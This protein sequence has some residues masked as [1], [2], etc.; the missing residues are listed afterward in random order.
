MVAL[1]SLFMWVLEKHFSYFFKRYTDYLCVGN[2]LM[3][4]ITDIR[5]TGDMYMYVSKLSQ[6]TRPFAA[7]T[8]ETLWGKYES[9]VVRLINNISSKN[10]K[11]APTSIEKLDVLS[12]RTKSGLERFLDVKLTDKRKNK[13]R[14]LTCFFELGLNDGLQQLS[15][16]WSKVASSM[17]AELE[18]AKVMPEQMYLT[19]CTATETLFMVTEPEKHNFVMNKRGLECSPNQYLFQANGDEPHE[20][21]DLTMLESGQCDALVSAYHLVD[22]AVESGDISCGGGLGL[23]NE[24]QDLDYLQSQFGLEPA[25]YQK[26][27]EPFNY[28]A[29]S[30]DTDVMVMLVNRPSN[31]TIDEMLSQLYGLSGS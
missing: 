3:S 31:E 21:P 11:S 19:Y 9:E 30:S 2:E 10:I 23:G 7:P 28:F 16:I 26:D 25:K 27:C 5:R 1:G 20:C 29:A 6:N 14:D 18:L 4:A 24:S 12:E 15:H 13:T 22:I 17:A 8:L